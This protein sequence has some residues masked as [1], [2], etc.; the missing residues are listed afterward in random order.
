MVNEQARGAEVG[1]G[2]TGASNQTNDRAAKAG[3][4]AHDVGM[5]NEQLRGAEVRTLLMLTPLLLMLKSLPPNPNTHPFFVVKCSFLPPFRR[6][7]FHPL[8]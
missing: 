7:S 5:T 2:A 8:L 3:A 6:I 4:L 1:K